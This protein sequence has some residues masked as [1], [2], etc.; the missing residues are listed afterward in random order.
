MAVIENGTL[1]AQRVVTGRIDDLGRLMREHAIAAPA[2]IVIGEVV[3]HGAAA[4]QSDGTEINAL[5]LAI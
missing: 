5:R 2:L 3:R 1:P 4:A